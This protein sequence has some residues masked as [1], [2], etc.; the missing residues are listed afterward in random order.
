M[1]MGKPS[2]EEYRLKRLEENKKRMEALNLP[3]LSQAL[4]KTPSNS[5]KPSPVIASLKHLFSR[6]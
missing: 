2:Y 6:V 4:R 5:L 3:Q 1:V